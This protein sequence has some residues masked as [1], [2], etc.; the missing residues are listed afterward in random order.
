[1]MRTRKFIVLR[2]EYLKEL[3]KIIGGKVKNGI[4][5]LTSEEGSQR[6]NTI[7]WLTSDNSLVTEIKTKKKNSKSFMLFEFSSSES[8]KTVAKELKCSF[9]NNIVMLELMKYDGSNSSSQTVNDENIFHIIQKGG[10][11]IKTKNL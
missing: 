8:A 3:Q 10:H 4:W 9:K 1:M 7:T 2:S 11:Y 5:Y 6:D